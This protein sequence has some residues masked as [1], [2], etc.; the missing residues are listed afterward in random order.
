MKT[1]NAAKVVSIKTN[2]I[3][4]ELETFLED[5]ESVKTIKKYRHDINSFF[6]FIYNGKEVGQITKKDIECYELD[7]EGHAQPVSNKQIIQYKNHLRTINSDG[8]VMSKIYAIK[9]FYKYLKKNRYKVDLLAFEVK[10]LK[11]EPNSYDILSKDEVMTMAELAKYERNGDELS[12]LIL[13]AAVTSIRLGALLALKWTDIHKD[14]ES[15]LHIVNAIDKGKKRSIRPIEQWL[16]D[17]LIKIKLKYNNELFFP[18]LKVDKVEKT[19]KRLAV[20]MGLAE[21]RRIVPHSLRKTALDYEMKTRANIH[22]ALQQSGHKKAQTL[23]DHYVDKKVDFQQ[24]AGIMMMK[25]VDESALEEMSKED[26]L[27]MLKQTNEG[28]YNQ[29]AVKAAYK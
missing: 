29:L 22:K 7:E 11:G 4:E 19:V 20:K 6:I 21:H 18:H 17:D 10:E 3:F 5:F 8:T 12:A 26:L 25:K 2:T 28:V 27:A 15:D 13:M 1:S 9:S 23:L 14:A 16:Y 24:L